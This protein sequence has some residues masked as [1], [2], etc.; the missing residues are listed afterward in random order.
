MKTNNRYTELL[1][2]EIEELVNQ[3][4]V[5][6][7][8]EL[9]EAF[10]TDEPSNSRFHFYLGE[11]YHQHFREY[12][13]AESHYR[14][15]IKFGPPCVQAFLGL[16]KLLLRTG[17]AEEAEAVIR[18]GLHFGACTS[19]AFEA[20]GN[21]YERAGKYLLARRHYKLALK[22]SMENEFVIAQRS[23]LKRCRIK[24]FLF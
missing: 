9:L 8:K 21:V 4:R 3:G 17:R 15:A 22:N 6:Q 18:Q 14:L 10:L 1:P 24:M 23:N 5:A 19:A 13:L 12:L 7:A 2:F 20:L 16:G 11:L